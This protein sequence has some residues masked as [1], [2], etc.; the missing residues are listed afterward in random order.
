MIFYTMLGN[1]LTVEHLMPSQE[2]PGSMEFVIVVYEIVLN[3]DK[4]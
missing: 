2:G 4:F 1:S 3:V